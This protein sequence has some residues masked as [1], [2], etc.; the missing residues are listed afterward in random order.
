MDSHRVGLSHWNLISG[1]ANAA[2][3]QRFLACPITLCLTV[4]DPSTPQAQ[5]LC[6]PRQSLSLMVM[7]FAAM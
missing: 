4:S 7:V 1:G 2:L 6:L 3:L 5:V